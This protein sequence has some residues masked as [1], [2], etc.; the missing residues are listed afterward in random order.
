MRHGQHFAAP[1]IGEDFIACQNFFVQGNIRAAGSGKDLVV[2]LVDQRNC[3]PVGFYLFFILLLAHQ[4]FGHQAAHDIGLIFAGGSDE[5]IHI[6]QPGRQQHLLVR[7][8]TEEH[9]GILQLGG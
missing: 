1:N 6:Q 3:F 9:L 2:L 7:P 5:G 4:V 8:V